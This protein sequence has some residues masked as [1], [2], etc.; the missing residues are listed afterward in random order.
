MSALSILR[1][2]ALAAVASLLLFAPPARAEWRKATSEHFVIYGNTSE[3]SLR[4]YAQKV[5]RF[6]RVLRTWFP[7]RDPDVIPPRLTIYLAD[8]RADMLKVWP[9]M[10]ESVG[11]F[12]TAGEERIFAVTGGT[13]PENDHTLFHEYGHH[14]MYQNLN[15]A[16]PGWFSEGF[17]EFF[18][19]ADLSPSRMRIGLHS[20]GRM[21]SLTLGT[22]S[23]MPMEQVLRSRSYDTGSRGHFYYAQSWALTHYLMSTPERQAKLFLY[24]GAINSGRDPV[25]ALAGTIDRTPDQ[26]QD[27]VRRYVSGR[28]NFLSQ[29]YA[30][31]P[32]DVTVTALSPA[33][34]E[35]IW[36]DLRLARFVPEPLRAANLAEAQGV[37][38]RYP[39][40]PFAARVLAQ[41][42]L[43]MQQPNEAVEVMRPIAGAHP[44]EP[45]GQRFFAVTLMDAGDKAEEDGDPDRRQ[46]LY[47]EARRA[48]ARAYAADGLDYRT[49]LALNRNRRG[50]STYP[51]DNDLEVLRNGVDLA[52]QVSALRYQAAQAM[53][54]RGQFREAV[55]YL[56]PLA[57]N[58]HGGDRLTEIR[59]LLQQ[60]M[61]MAGM[62]HAAG[63][64]EPEAAPAPA[65]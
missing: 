59:A 43:D 14:Y 41:A 16:F 27:D 29:P 9:D 52:P 64:A 23:W 45:L 58:P 6:D 37:A 28:I 34:S 18:A 3:G 51:S 8:G 36:L 13:G 65:S 56:M 26:L 24:L 25:E 20:P 15:G 47:S 12:Y 57:N 32:S 53:M 38:A 62:V 35:L 11:G 1:A 50:A 40:D 44:D 10:P 5:E 54:N 33:E 61:E 46:S 39:G 31:P 42:Y 60:A 49:Y 63:Q 7:P 4:N 48:L 19:T 30:F 55:F 17:A 21:N 22:N 2:M